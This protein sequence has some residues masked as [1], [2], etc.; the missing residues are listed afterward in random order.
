MVEEG[1]AKSGPA[2]E[3]LGT[4]LALENV[5]R[6]DVPGKTLDRGEVLASAPA[7]EAGKFKVT[8]I[9]GDGV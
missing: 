4:P 3:P 9:L 1:E 2:P 6:A 8:S 7:A 5:L